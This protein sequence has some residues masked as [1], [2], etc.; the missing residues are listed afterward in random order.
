LHGDPLFLNPAA[1]DYHLT[2]G[3]PAVDAG[4]ASGVVDDVD[5][6]WR[7]SDGDGDGVG[8]FDV[9][10]DEHYPLCITPLADLS[11]TGPISGSVGNLHTFTA[12][13]TPSDATGP[14]TYDWSPEP[15]VGAGATVSYRWESAGTKEI[16]VTA[17]NCGGDGVASHTIVIESGTGGQRH[18]FLPV[19]LRGS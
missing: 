19:I 11:I 1:G 17:G 10:A 6:D 3:S 7:P 2:A 14:V 4:V 15:D 9:G 8:E 5:G 18:L 13:P 16:T 12:A